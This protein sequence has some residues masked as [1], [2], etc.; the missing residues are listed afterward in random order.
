[1]NWNMPRFTFDDVDGSDEIRHYF[2]NFPSDRD[3]GVVDHEGDTVRAVAW[4]V[5][6]PADEPG[7]GFV[8]ADTPELCITTFEGFRGKGIGSALLSE[9][10][11]SAKSRGLASISLSV[12]DDNPARRLYERTGF[13]VVGRNGASDTM[14]L[15]LD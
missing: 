6:L 9:L 11:A 13:R 12:E 5:F 14:L 2:L 3:F 7:Y 15:D 8:H 4:L 1:M 10:L